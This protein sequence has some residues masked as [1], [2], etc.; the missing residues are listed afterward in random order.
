MFAT[1][2]SSTAGWLLAFLIWFL[3]W[4]PLVALLEYATHRWIMHMANRVLDPKLSQLHAHDAHHGG[5]LPPHLGELKV[6]LS[7]NI[8]PEGQPEH[9]HARLK[10]SLLE[11]M[12]HGAKALGVALLPPGK[13]KPF[14]D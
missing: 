4:T 2:P 6:R 8:W 7:I 1:L 5:V 12:Q 14:D 11:V 13:A 3:I 9:F 10:D